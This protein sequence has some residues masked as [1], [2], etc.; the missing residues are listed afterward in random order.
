MQSA[1]VD[2]HHSSLPAHSPDPPTAATRADKVVPFLAWWAGGT[3]KGERPAAPRIAGMS[4]RG[5]NKAAWTRAVLEAAAPDGKVPLDSK[6][7]VP[8]P[9]RNSVRR[10]AFNLL[11][12]YRPA[13]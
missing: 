7:E 6:G 1:C 2:A 10:A 4:F 5:E 3:K 13:A 9:D 11:A 12:T 8:K